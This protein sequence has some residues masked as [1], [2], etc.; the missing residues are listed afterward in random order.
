MYDIPRPLPLNSWIRCSFCDGQPDFLQSL[1]WFRWTRSAMIEQRS[2]EAAP[3]AKTAVGN[4]G[5]AHEG[6][7]HP[8]MLRSKSWCLIWYLLF[9]WCYL[10]LSA[11]LLSTTWQQTEMQIQADLG[12]MREWS[13]RFETMTSKQVSRLNESAPTK[14]WKF[15][16][17][18]ANPQTQL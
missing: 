10:R 15:S 16:F 4:S 9:K 7:V 8:W 17:P 6:L 2:L 3:I 11:Q 14:K 1:A 13:D 5:S 12:K 18:S